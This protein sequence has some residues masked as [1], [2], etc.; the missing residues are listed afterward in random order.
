MEKA[1]DETRARRVAKRCAGLRIVKGTPAYILVV[2]NKAERAASP[3][4]FDEHISKRKWE[5]SMMDF[6]SDLRATLRQIHVTDHSGGTA[7]GE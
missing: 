3:D 2:M 6:R 1:S 4:P 5:K 7:T